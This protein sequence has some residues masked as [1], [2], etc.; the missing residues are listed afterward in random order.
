MKRTMKELCA[1]A[2]SRAWD[3]MTCREQ[4][5]ADN[6]LWNGGAF[7]RSEIAEAEKLLN[8]LLK[9]YGITEDICEK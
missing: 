3:R 8:K 5:L 1:K 6:I 4:S 2:V 9:K 7:S